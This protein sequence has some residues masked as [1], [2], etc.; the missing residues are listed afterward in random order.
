MTYNNI[1]HLELLKRF[2]YL[3]NQAKDLYTENRYEYMELQNYR[4][5]LYHHILWEKK[6]K[7][8]LLMENYTHNWINEEQFEIAF[9]QLWRERMEVYDTFEVDLKGLKNFE[10]DVASD[11]FGSL[12]TAIF[13]QFEVLEDE[14]LSEQEFKAYVQKILREIRSYI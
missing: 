14:E 12:V 6:E 3:K 11:R 1:R 10:L 9:S 7:F 13:R 4:C 2:L 8:I 5:A